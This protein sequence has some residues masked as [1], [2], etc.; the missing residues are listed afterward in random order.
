MGR[1]FIIDGTG[2]VVRAG[3]RVIVRPL[4]LVDNHGPGVLVEICGEYVAIVRLDCGVDEETLLV[5]I[6]REDDNEESGGSPLWS[7]R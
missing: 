3:D 2:R 5:R 1:D 6:R 4:T 7:W